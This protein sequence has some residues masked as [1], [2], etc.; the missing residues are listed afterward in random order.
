MAN[1][2][3]QQKKTIVTG[4]GRKTGK[5]LKQFDRTYKNKEKAWAKHLKKYP[6]DG[7][8]KEEIKKAR[9]STRK[10]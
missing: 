4:K 2:R 3:E 1:P 8:A 9:E 10:G 5:Y 6:N 7:T